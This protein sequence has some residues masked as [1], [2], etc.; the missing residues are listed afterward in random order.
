M[1]RTLKDLMNHP[2]TPI[3]CL[4][5]GIAASEVLGYRMDMAIGYVLAM[6]LGVLAAVSM[7]MTYS[8]RAVK[9]VIG[10]LCAMLLLTSVVDIGKTG[11]QPER[12]P[13]AAI[14]A[15]QNG[16]AP[17]YSGSGYTS[18]GYGYSSYGR[19]DD[20]DALYVREKIRVDCTAC[21]KTGKC[22]NCNGTGY[23]TRTKSG[24]MG[25][26]YEA[27]ER[28]ALCMGER[29]CVKCDGHGYYEY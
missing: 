10:F 24:Y 4:V 18:G 12:T 1:N 13:A 2:A 9:A 15:Q 25:G 20:D 6:P 19:Y 23:I 26:T 27:K 8:N 7:M 16:S 21:H 17:T 11:R 22:S 14:H 29:K 28:C 5:T 3:V